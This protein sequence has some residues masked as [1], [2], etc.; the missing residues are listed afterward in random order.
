MQDNANAYHIY[1]SIVKQRKE[2]EI[3]KIRDIANVAQSVT[4]LSTFLETNSCN[5]T[6]LSS[7]PDRH[8][9]RSILIKDSAGKL[10][11]ILRD[12]EEKVP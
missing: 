9:R 10:E 1:P 3:I 11:D 5:A 4:Q 8:Q 2:S 6:N 12:V 7:I